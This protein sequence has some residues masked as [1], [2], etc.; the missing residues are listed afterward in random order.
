MGFVRPSA[1]RST[2]DSELNGSPVLFA[3]R[4]LTR[5]LGADRLA[6]HRE[7]ER[8][9][10]AHDREGVVRVAGRVHLAGGAD[11]AHAEQPGRH[12]G[13][14]RIDLR[15]LA[16]VIGFVARV[17]FSHQRR[18]QVRTRQMTG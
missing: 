15:I 3:P 8:L 7:H 14:G 2:A 10:H 17:R 18:Y 13:Q 9:R 12:R 11:H 5:L 16:F 1:L 6:D 4:L